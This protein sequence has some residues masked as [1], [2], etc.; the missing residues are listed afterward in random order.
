MSELY[1]EFDHQHAPIHIIRFTGAQPTDDGFQAYLNGL[2]ALYEDLSPLAIV[3]D[4]EQGLN[5]GLRYQRMQADWLK[6]MDGAMRAYCRGTA[7]VIKSALVRMTLRAIFALQPQP[8]PY[9]ITADRDEAMQWCRDQL[10]EDTPPA[11]GSS[12]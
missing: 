6:R 7:Y 11:V 2:S 9:K 3:F 5:I 4:A 12:S 10:A 8:A 1:T